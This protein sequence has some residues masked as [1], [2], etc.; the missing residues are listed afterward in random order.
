VTDRAFP[1]L[2]TTDLPAARAFY[3]RLGFRQTYQFPPDGEPGY[4]ALERGASSIGIGA[5]G[6]ADEDRLAIWIYVD[7]VDGAVADLR[8]DGAEVLTDPEDQPW[9]ERLARVRD[10]AGT[11]VY[12]ATASDAD[13]GSRS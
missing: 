10:P 6:S 8:R 1:I 9:G 4:V 13:A 12:V 11:L 7:D 5:A 3:E 2:S